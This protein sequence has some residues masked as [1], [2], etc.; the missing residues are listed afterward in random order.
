MKF[1]DIPD[2]SRITDDPDNRTTIISD[3]K[4]QQDGVEI[5]KIE[6]LEYKIKFEEKLGNYSIITALIQTDLGEIEILYDE[7]YRGTNALQDSANMLTQNLGLS[8]LI[9]RSLISLKNHIGKNWEVKIIII[10]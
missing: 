10:N 2:S 8:G 7:G 1:I 6:L 5:N 9:L 3:G 4:I